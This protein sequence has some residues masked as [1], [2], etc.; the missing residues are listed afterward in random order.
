M[1]WTKGN[2]ST[3]TRRKEENQR[4]CQITGSWRQGGNHVDTNQNGGS[5]DTKTHTCTDHSGLR[6]VSSR[7]PRRPPP[8]DLQELRPEWAAGQPL[9][10]L[11]KDWVPTTDSG[12]SHP[13]PFPRHTQ[14][15]SEGLAAPASTQEAKELLPKEDELLVWEGP[16]PVVGQPLSRKMGENN[17]SAHKRQRRKRSEKEELFYHEK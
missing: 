17:H 2:K 14:A 5:Q 15:N 12:I 1:R 6:Q 7:G 8:R 4:F 3:K 16:R 9:G 11:G 10:S 13:S